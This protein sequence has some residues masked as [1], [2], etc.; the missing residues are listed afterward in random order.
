[1]DKLKQLEERFEFNP[2][3]RPLLEVVRMQREALKVY[4]NRANW[5]VG[6][7]DNVMVKG[8]K[9]FSSGWLIS[10]ESITKTD[11]IL[12]GMEV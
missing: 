5:G 12:D 11:E 4:G 1:M 6:T 10:K 3:I 2:N 8:M 9:G 7:W